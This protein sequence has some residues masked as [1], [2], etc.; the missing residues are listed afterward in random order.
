MFFSMSLTFTR[1]VDGYTVFL[2]FIKNFIP[3]RVQCFRIS[4]YD[5]SLLKHTSA[6]IFLLHNSFTSI[7]FSIVISPIEDTY[8]STLDKL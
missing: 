6:F 3:E 8:T 1:F 4:L 7:I 5:K 2:K